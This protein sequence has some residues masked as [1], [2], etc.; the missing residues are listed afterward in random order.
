MRRGIDPVVYSTEGLIQVAGLGCSCSCC[1][2]CKLV[3]YRG[4]GCLLHVLEVD[5]Y[6]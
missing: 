5:Q 3:A 6:K 1:R 2:Y 4:S